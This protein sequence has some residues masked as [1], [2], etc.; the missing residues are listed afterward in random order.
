MPLGLDEVLRDHWP[1]FARRHATRLAAAH[2]RAAR[3]VLSCRTPVLGGHVWHCSCHHNHT[4][5]SY[6]SCNHRSCPQCG[7]LDQQKWAA[8]Q[9]ARLLPGVPYFLL[10]LTVPDMLHGMCKFKPD[11]LYDLLLREAAGAVKDL[12]RTKL[13]GN[14]GFTTVLHTWGRHMQHHP[15]VH[16]I[17]PGVALDADGERLHFPKQPDFLFHGK[18]LAVRFRNRL[19]IALKADHPELH[20]CLL[21]QHPQVF[22]CKWVADVAHTGG[23]RPAL[24]YLARYVFRSALGPKRILGY[25]RKG[26]IRLQCYESG[27]NRPHVIALRVETFLRRWL[28]HVLPKGFVR[29][30]HHGWMGGAARKTRLRVRALVCGELD[31][32][33]PVLPEAPVPRCPHCGATMKF[34]AVINPRGPPTRPKT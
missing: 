6:H 31:E 7:S 3:A 17:V 19:E 4:H 21:K 29:V 27:T 30:R 14:P 20:A 22:R 11:I 18:P 32:P 13:G 16:V 26:R 23:G 12:C 24:R 8:T 9:E 33:K 5:F 25:D 1:G 15:H 2:Y 10:T 28:T 34:L